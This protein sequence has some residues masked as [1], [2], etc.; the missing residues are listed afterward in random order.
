[1]SSV[2]CIF[3]NLQN[4]CKMVNSIFILSWNVQFH[5]ISILPSQKGLE[6]AGGGGSQKK[7]LLWGRYGSMFSRITQF[8]VI[9]LKHQAVKKLI[10]INITLIKWPLSNSLRVQGFNCRARNCD[11]FVTYFCFLRL[12]KREQPQICDQVL[13]CLI[14]NTL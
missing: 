4:L 6:F 9:H 12:Q 13:P 3:Y 10:I 5:K 1:M 7:S 8:N 11:L 14:Q 2:I